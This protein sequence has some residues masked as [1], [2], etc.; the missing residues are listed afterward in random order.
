MPKFRVHIFESVSARAS[1]VFEAA[2]EAD[3]IELAEDEDWSEW[4]QT[5]SDA[6]CYVDWVEEVTND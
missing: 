3:A 4:E 1:K 2:T 6:D 5:K